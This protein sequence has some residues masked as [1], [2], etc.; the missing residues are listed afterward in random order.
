MEQYLLKHK[1]LPVYAGEQLLSRG[2]TIDEIE[3][4][5]KLDLEGQLK[6]LGIS[7]KQ[8]EQMYNNNEF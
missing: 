7:Q 8:L 1:D 4:I 3:K 5:L 6:Y 2:Y